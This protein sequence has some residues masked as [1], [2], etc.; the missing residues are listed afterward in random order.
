[1]ITSN[2]APR[3]CTNGDETDA[4]GRRARRAHSWHRDSLRKVKRSTR[5]RERREARTQLRNETH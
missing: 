1:M 3:R 2:S 5:R 4:H